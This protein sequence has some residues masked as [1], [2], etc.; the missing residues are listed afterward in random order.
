MRHRKQGRK[1]G[2]T[3]GHRRALWRN[4]ALSLFIHERITTTPAKAKEARKLAERMIT[5]AKQK[6]LHSRRRA[7]AFLQD[8]EVVDKLFDDIAPRYEARNGGYTRILRLDQNRLGDNAPQVIFELVGPEEPAAAKAPPKAKKT[9]DAP[10]A[11][12]PQA[13]AAKDSAPAETPKADAPTEE[14]KSE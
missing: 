2:R 11:A 14:K 9:A 7:M 4:L 13:P 1:L 10:K 6:T 8:R 12:A 5:L 3:S